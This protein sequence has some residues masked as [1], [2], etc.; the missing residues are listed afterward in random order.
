MR[1]C[2]QAYRMQNDTHQEAV[3][4]D[5]CGAD[6]STFLAA[7]NGFRLVRCR[8]CSLV[9]VNPRP[10]PVALEAQYSIDSYVHHQHERA[11]DASWRPAALARLALIERHRSTKGGR[12]LDV[13]CSTG[14]FL[15]V[16]SQGGW[17]ATGIDVSPSAV[18][19]NRARGLDARLA[20]LERHEFG[21]PAFDVV[22]MFDS[23]EH[24]PSPMRA[25]AAARELLTDDGLL[26]VTT[27][28]I[29]G[30]LPA[31]TYQMFCRTMGLWEHPT[32]PGHV[33]QFSS[34]TL[35]AA[36]GRAGF[37]PIHERTERIPL[38]HT[39]GELEDVFV[40]V[41]KQRGRHPADPGIVM[42]VDSTRPATSRASAAASPDRFGRIARRGVRGVA[43]AASWALAGALSAPA[44]LLGRGD[45][46]VVI[47]KKQ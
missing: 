19:Y 44:P 10:R 8:K 9:Y 15:S 40:G 34:A 42:E 17:Q 45:S 20:T 11:D 38:D 47:A 23:I 39:V 35:R 14:W 21:A 1:R 2:W 18:A 4:C 43:R 33:Y 26:V 5:L 36:L 28:N 12:L 6:D 7:K 37:A 32:P 13:G 24:M 29:D 30:L 16:A 3:A 27:P 31:T 46:L 25:L 41:L 22:T